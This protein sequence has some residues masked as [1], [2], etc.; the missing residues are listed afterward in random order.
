VGRAAACRRPADVP[1]DASPT[2]LNFRADVTDFVAQDTNSISIAPRSSSASLI[3]VGATLI[4]LYL[5]PKADASVLDPKT[6]RLGSLQYREIIIEDG[7]VS[8]VG[9]PAV[10]TSV[11]FS[12][13]FGGP[14]G[15]TTWIVSD[16]QHQSCSMISQG[17]EAATRFT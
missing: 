12:K 9:P 16:A 6:N 8:F 11:V 15:K 14:E 3:P 5:D 10:S 1:D 2:L 4:A 13:A 17:F 7:A